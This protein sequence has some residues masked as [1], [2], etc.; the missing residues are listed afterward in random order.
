MNIYIYIF[1]YNIYIYINKYI[2]IY[3]MDIYIYIN[4]YIYIYRCK[5]LAAVAAPV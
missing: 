5:L 3:F 2:Y 4:V 1:T